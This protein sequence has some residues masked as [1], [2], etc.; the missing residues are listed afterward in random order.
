MVVETLPSSLGM[1]VFVLDKADAVVSCI[2]N[3][4]PSHTQQSFSSLCLI[5]NTLLM[6]PRL[7]L[8]LC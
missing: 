1:V 6:V 7:S 8:L 5:A 4:H 2:P 3:V